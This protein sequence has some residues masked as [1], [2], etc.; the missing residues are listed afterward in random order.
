MKRLLIA[1]VIAIPALAQLPASNP[2]SAPS[3]LQFHAPLFDR[4]KGS[5][6]KPALDEGMKEQI[7]EIEKI[8]NNKEPASFVNTIEAMERSGALLTRVAKV[9]FNLVQSNTNDTFDKVEAEE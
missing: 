5:D 6:Y 8:A 9:F 3:P 1:L 4:I 7:A 2:F